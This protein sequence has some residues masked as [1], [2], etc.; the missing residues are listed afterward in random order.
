MKNFATITELKDHQREAVAKQ[1]RSRVGALFMDMG[2]GKSRTAIELAHYRASRIRNVVW[3]CPVS[4]KETIRHE[5]RK[6]TDAAPEDICVFDDKIRQRNINTRCSWYVVGIESMSSSVR[7]KFAADSII[8]ERSMVIVDESSYIKGHRSERTNWIT[9]ISQRARYRLILTGTPITQGVQDLYA[10]MRFLSPRILGYSSF[11]SFSNNHLE[12]SEKYPGMIVRAHHTE[13][14]AA[15]IQPYVYQV[16]RQECMNLP[17]RLYETRVCS[18][19]NSQAME[20]E[21]A[22]WRI[23]NLI[24]ADGELDSYAIFQLFTQ[25]Q[26]IASGFVRCEENGKCIDKDLNHN[27]LE[28]LQQVVTECD[29]SAKIIVWAKYRHNIHAITETLENTFGEKCC[30][31]YYGDIR[32]KDRSEA[33]ARWQD[34]QGPRI[35][36]A[37]QSTGSHG[38][39]LTEATY[40]IFYNNGFKY[41]DRIQAEARIHRYGQRRQVTYIDVTTDSGIDERINDA[42]RKKGDTLKDFRDEVDK[43]KDKGKLK[44]LVESL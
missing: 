20:Y 11:Y 18:L 12:Y 29:S 31:Q 9:Q 14:L 22:K 2:T 7:C 19:T 36:V 13:W 43:I 21:N 42:L 3:F 10:Q 6:H 4:L 40:V 35:L 1:A 30:E 26:Q 24:D 5:I 23:L 39:N 17:N 28:L 15:K 16:T 44:K 34:P 37:T 41:A 8:S 33:I 25:L 27:R 38:L 32:E